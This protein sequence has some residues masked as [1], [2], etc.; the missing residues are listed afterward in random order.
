MSFNSRMRTHA[1]HL[2]VLLFAVCVGIDAVQA[3][4]IK[5]YTPEKGSVERKQLLDAV[6]PQVEK[7]LGKKVV[8][9]VRAMQIEGD[10]A[11]ALLEPT[12]PNGKRIAVGKGG[13]AD[14]DWIECAFKRQGGRW[15]VIAI[16]LG[17]QEAGFETFRQIDPNLPEQLLQAVGVATNCDP[18]E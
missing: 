9:I 1:R 5:R 7:S 6:R 14:E 15:T 3:K 12:T 8:F 11:A 13:P 10:Y 17:T 4:E 16:D 2:I 18:C